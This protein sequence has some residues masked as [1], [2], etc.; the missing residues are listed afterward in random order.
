MNN[1]RVNQNTFYHILIIEEKETICKTLLIKIVPNKIYYV[2]LA[3]LFEDKFNG[4]K[5]YCYCNFIEL[6]SKKPFIVKEL[7]L[8][9]NKKL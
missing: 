3:S 8:E 6:K 7:R 4:N 9:K 2:Q 1:F 5:Y